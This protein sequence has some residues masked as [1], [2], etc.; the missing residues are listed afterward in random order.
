MY[1]LIFFKRRSALTVGKYSVSLWMIVIT[2]Y[3]CEDI[4]MCPTFLVPHTE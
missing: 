1:A 4:G 2:R 3:K